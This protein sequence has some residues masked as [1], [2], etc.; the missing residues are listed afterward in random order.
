MIAIIYNLGGSPPQTWSPVGELAYLLHQFICHIQVNMSVIAHI[1]S[2][3]PLYQ[4]AY[5]ILT[6]VTVFEYEHLKGGLPGRKFL[7]T[8]VNTNHTAITLTVY[9][10][11]I[12]LV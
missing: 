5:K 10:A 1:L 9:S 3:L 12:H 7:H 11:T 6:I 2:C 8:M 4:Y